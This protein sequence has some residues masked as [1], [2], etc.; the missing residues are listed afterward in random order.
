MSAPQRCS[1]RSGWP[2]S[3]SSSPGPFGSTFSGTLRVAAHWMFLL[4]QPGM[5]TV[6]WTSFGTIRPPPAQAYS[7]VSRWSTVTMSPA[8]IRVLAMATL[9]PAKSERDKYYFVLKVA[10][11]RSS[12][13]P[14]LRIQGVRE[15]RHPVRQ[16]RR[17]DGTDRRRNGRIETRPPVCH[18]TPGGRLAAPGASINRKE[19]RCRFVRL[20]VP[21]SLRCFAGQLG[22]VTRQ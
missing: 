19:W 17:F 21:G 12:R 4:A 16:G 15:E 7:G 14:S 3:C 8:T 10:T 20:Y 2:R 11:G 18:S 5:S 22:C 6:P 13:P 1:T 9:D